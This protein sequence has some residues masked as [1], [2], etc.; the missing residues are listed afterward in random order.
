LDV[1][2]QVEGVERHPA[3]Q[4]DVDEHQRVVVG[5][6]DVD[7]VRRV[8]CAQVRQFHALAADVQGHAVRERVVWDRPGWVVVTQ[9]QGT[10]LDLADALDVVAEQERSAEVVGVVVGV[11]HVRDLVRHAGGVGG[12]VDSPL[13]V[14]ADG[15]RGVEQHHAF[16]GEQERSLVGAVGDP[17]EVAVDLP[18]VVAVGVE[19][20]AEG[21]GRDRGIDREVRARGGGRRAGESGPGDPGQRGH[22][23]DS[24]GAGQELAAAG[25]FVQQRHGRKAFRSFRSGENPGPGFRRLSQ[26]P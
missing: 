6:V 17:V 9:Q 3:R 12:V 25:G 19:R 18:G 7:V 13:Q 10:G 23:R 22:G 14:V 11:H 26:A 20:W 5:E 16:L 1:L 2:V 8:V 24:C 21:G 15:R 4:V